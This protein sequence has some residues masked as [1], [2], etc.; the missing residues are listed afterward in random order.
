MYFKS[1]RTNNHTAHAKTLTLSFGFHP[2][3]DCTRRNTRDVVRDRHP[4]NAVFKP[5]TLVGIGGARLLRRGACGY[6]TQLSSG[7]AEHLTSDSQQILGLANIDSKYIVGDL[8]GRAV[9]VGCIEGYGV[10]HDKGA[11]DEQ[12][13]KKGERMLCVRMGID[14]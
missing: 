5:Y 6:V 7:A 11:V 1:T 13:Q 2:I 14:G 3:L 4:Q 9:G 8:G 10:Q 12:Q